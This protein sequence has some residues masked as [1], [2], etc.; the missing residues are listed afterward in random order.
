MNLKKI[1]LSL[2]LGIFSVGI[3]TGCDGSKKIEKEQTTET[4][5]GNCQVLDC[6]K[7]IEV[8]NSVKE[9]NEIIGVEGEIS[10]TSKNVKWKLNS[11]ESITLTYAGEAPILQANYDRTTIKN[12]QNDFSSYSDIAD[13]LKKGKTVT[14][15]EIKEIVGGL[16]GTLEGK[17]SSSNSYAWVDKNGRVLRATIKNDKKKS[18]SIISL[19]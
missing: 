7:Q 9:I 3:I 19:R 18:C 5:Q 8:T 12:E 6:I 16:D 2:I 13:K 10:D 11:K 15:E 4:S 14:Y 1:F 17:T